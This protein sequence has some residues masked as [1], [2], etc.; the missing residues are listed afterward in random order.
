MY[1]FAVLFSF[2]AGAHA[3]VVTPQS[4]VPQAAQASAAMNQVQAA[5]AGAPVF[6]GSA[7]RRDG[8]LLIESEQKNLLLKREHLPA[9]SYCETDAD[10]G[11]P[12]PHMMRHCTPL[13][14]RTES[15][16]GDVQKVR[17]VDRDAYNRKGMLIGGLVGG[18]IGLL[19]FLALLAGPIGL[20]I[21][22]GLACVAIGAG[23]G[24]GIGYEVASRKPDEFNRVVNEK[25][26]TTVP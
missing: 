22:I 4:A 13:P 21:G 16:Y 11:D 5:E 24:V 15:T 8:P 17:I 2:A 12:R 9:G 1:L 7:P 26:T 3:Q 20:G 18:G 14:P 25:T 23:V 19:G 10:A 6:D